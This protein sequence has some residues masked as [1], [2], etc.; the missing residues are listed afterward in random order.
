[1]E[2]APLAWNKTPKGAYNGINYMT[3]TGVEAYT[4]R[5]EAWVLEGR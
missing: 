3:G 4:R 2:V 1:M 5:T